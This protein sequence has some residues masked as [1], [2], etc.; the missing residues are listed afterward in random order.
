LHHAEQAV[1]LRSLHALAK[2]KNILRQRELVLVIGQVHVAAE[3]TAVAHHKIGFVFDR[4]H[5]LEHG[6]AL[7]RIDAERAD[8]INQRV[9][10]D[11]FLLR[12]ATQNQLEFGSCDRL[13]NDMKNVVTNDAFGS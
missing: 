2:K 3:R 5:I 1:E 11:V 12:V 4:L 6:L 8:H 7:V 13:A 10:V 9:G